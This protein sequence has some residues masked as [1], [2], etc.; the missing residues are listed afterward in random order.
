M[1]AKDDGT[2][3]APATPCNKRAAISTSEVGAAAIATEAMP[4]RISPTF[5]TR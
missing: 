1:S 4:N 2:S 3:I 5:S